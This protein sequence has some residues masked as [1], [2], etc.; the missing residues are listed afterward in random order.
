[1]NVSGLTVHNYCGM[2]K[3]GRDIIANYRL[4]GGAAITREFADLEAAAAV[5]RRANK[6][7]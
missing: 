7:A 6:A 2:K 4:P 5:S 3:R 1:L